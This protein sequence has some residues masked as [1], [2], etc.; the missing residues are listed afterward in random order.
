M[1]AKL[2]LDKLLKKKIIIIFILIL[3]L[4]GF[5]RV[6]RL[7]VQSFIA[8]EYIGINISYGY[9]QTNEWKFWNFNDE[10]L[11]DEKYTRAQVYYW[12]VAQLFKFLEPTEANSRLISVL[13][14]MIGMIT[15]F[16]GSFY[17][18][19]KPKLALIAAFLLAVSIAALT[20]DRKLRMYSM[21]APMFFIFS[22]LVYSTL[23]ILP[24]KM[25]KFGIFSKKVGI[26][27]YLF[28]VL[29]L[30]GYLNIKVHLLA[31]NII[32]ILLSYL[33]IMSI[34]KFKNNKSLKNKYFIY[35]LIGI[36][37]FFLSTQHIIIH[38]ALIFFEPVKFHW[39][40]LNKIGLDYSYLLLALGVISVGCWHMVKKHGKIGLWAVLSLVV[41]LFMA[42]FVWN[43]NV[44][45]QYI[46]F[47]NIFKV[48]IFACGI[49]YISQ[50]FSTNLR[51]KN[52]N[53]ILV[54]II[55]IL[56]LNFPFFFS[57]KSFYG[58]PKTWE[59]PNYRES[60]SFFLDKKGEDDVL[61]TR[62]LTNYYLNASD[63]NTF[64][65]GSSD[66]KL[67]L[68]SVLMLQKQ[69]PAVWLITSDGDFNIKSETKKYIK[70]NFELI[71]T[72]YTNDDIQIWRW[73]KQNT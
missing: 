1:I 3:L 10:R 72:K 21:F 4:A 52:H 51:V 37:S 41:P 8:D 71:K 56:S 59:L 9:H 58:N 31:V 24:K 43:W 14:G 26:N 68:E 65:Y 38:S 40:Y 62:D 47:T 11:T 27:L 48:M 28:P 53:I 18:T 69:Y 73:K 44:G 39:T 22:M 13:W 12:Q 6:Y 63:T 46:H 55:T 35:L 36:G 33:L 25:N 34:I 23:E 54:F 60:F 45:Q 49:Y 66:N 19:R 2:G 64:I 5:L 67:T 57:G 7:G 20:F 50:I 17:V 42:I 29:L 30:V 15:I 32:P 70:A 16:L 61:I